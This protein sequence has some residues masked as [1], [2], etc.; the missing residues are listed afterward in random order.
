M[1]FRDFFSKIA[2]F[3]AVRAEEEQE[4]E[5]EVVDHQAVLRESC[6]TKGHITQLYE[7]YQAC[8]DRVNA[9]SKTTE[10][11]MEELFDYYHELDHCVAHDLWPKLK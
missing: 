10:T 5:Q 6:A 2:S 9:K 3:P 11:C 8:N 4:E 7:K 1:A